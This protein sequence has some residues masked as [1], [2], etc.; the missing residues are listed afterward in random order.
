MQIYRCT[1]RSIV[2][3]LVE[4]K[5]GD[6]RVGRSSLATGGVTKT[7]YLL[8]STCTSSTQEDPSRIKIVDWDVK[9]H[10]IQ[11]HKQNLSTILIQLSVVGRLAICT[12][13]ACTGPYY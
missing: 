2:A 5:T 3:Q 1:M 10:S 9:N 6:R 11:T 12:M 13:I 4:H 8:L 7:L